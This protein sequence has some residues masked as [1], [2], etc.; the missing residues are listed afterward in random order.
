MTC[1]NKSL[2]KWPPEVILWFM[3]LPLVAMCSPNPTVQI[4]NRI[5]YPYRF[6]LN[7]SIFF[8]WLCIYMLQ[9]MVMISITHEGSMIII[10]G[11]YLSVIIIILYA[12]WHER[13][14]VKELFRGEIY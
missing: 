3:N 7:W 12:F 2:P 10:S 11:R 6:S 8:D 1:K 9:Y 14:E 4:I 13:W 5:I